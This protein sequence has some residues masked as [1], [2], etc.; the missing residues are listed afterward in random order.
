MKHGTTGADFRA[1]REL[2]GWPQEATARALGV[3]DKTVKQWENPKSNW[4]PQPYAWEWMDK[5][6]SFRAAEI[7]RVFSVIDDYQTLH[8]DMDSVSLV[9]FRPHDGLGEMRGDD[10]P[11][12]VHN[13][14]MREIWQIL[15]EEGRYTVRFVWAEWYK[16]EP[17]KYPDAIW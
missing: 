8:P 1:C 12:N 7:E 14:T 11:S 15:A 16:A 2:L 17:D 9:L 10:R 5:E 4:E 13:A 3:A 6:L